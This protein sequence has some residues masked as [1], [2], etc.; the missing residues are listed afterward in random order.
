MY[1][2]KQH[3]NDMKEFVFYIAQCLRLAMAGMPYSPMSYTR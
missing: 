3:M 1:R 2:G